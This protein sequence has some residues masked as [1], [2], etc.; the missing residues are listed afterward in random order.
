MIK[1][2]QIKIRPRDNNATIKI[3]KLKSPN[4]DKVFIGHAKTD[5]FEAFFDFLNYEY[6]QYTRNLRQYSPMWEIL[7]HDIVIL[8]VLEEV[9]NG[10]GINKKKKHWIDQFPT[11]VNH[12]TKPKNTDLFCIYKISS[13]STDKV[14]IG[15]TTSGLE[16]R[17]NG[18][19]YKPCSSRE[20]LDH[21]DDCEAVIIESGFQDEETLSEREIYL[22]HAHYPYA[23]NDAHGGKP[24]RKC[25]DL[26]LMQTIYII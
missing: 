4:T 7:Q 22:I 9:M 17:L 3:Y 10:T 19:L 18:H 6:L 14:Y 25:I 2:N 15:K 1:L 12:F 20:L 26:N 5:D 8:D 11:S 13:P 24:L 23:V 16:C 21:Y